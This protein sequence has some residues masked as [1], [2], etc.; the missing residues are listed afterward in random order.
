MRHRLPEALE[1]K[2]AELTE[3]ITP[4]LEIVTGS[5]REVFEQ[6][7]PQLASDVI[8]DG[9]YLSGGGALLNNLDH[10]F[11]GELNL[12]VQR[13]EDPL[14]CAVKGA[15]QALDYIKTLEMQRG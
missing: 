5:V 4:L 11:Q 2:A 12:P 15:S 9:I 1:I 7:P 8:Q 14:F 6:I 3:V 13:V 10:Y